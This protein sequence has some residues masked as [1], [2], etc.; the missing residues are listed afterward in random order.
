M[1]LE[2]PEWEVRFRHWRTGTTRRLVREALNRAGLPIR[3]T[4]PA[5]ARSDLCNYHFERLRTPIAPFLHRLD[6][7]VHAWVADCLRKRIAAQTLGHPLPGFCLIEEFAQLMRWPGH[8]LASGLAMENTGSTPPA[9]LAAI[10][11]AERE[12]FLRNELDALLASFELW[13]RNWV[14]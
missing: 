5:S 4:D 6:G 8:D 7:V 1:A 2:H 11:L 10:L 14:L 3:H 9:R 13:L 12:A